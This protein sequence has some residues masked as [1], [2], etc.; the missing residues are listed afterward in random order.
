VDYVCDREGPDTIVALIEAMRAGAEPSKVPNLWYRA[1]DEVRFTH[2]GDLLDDLD[3]E[4]PGIAWDLLPMTRYR[5]HNWHAFPD[6]LARSPY[7]SIHTSLGCPYKC[8]FCCINAPFGKS[9]YR[10]WQPDSVA[11]EVETLV[12]KY[13]VRHIKFCDEMFVLNKEHV[14]GICDRFIER[15]FDVNIWA[16]A[17]VDTVRDE[18]LD[19]LKRAGFNW[20]CLGIESASQHVRDGAL[21]KYGSQDIT[22]TVR[23]IQ[24]AGINVIGNYIFGLRDDTIASMRETLDMAVELNC[25]F[26]NFYSAMAYPGSKLYEQAVAKF[27]ALPKQWHHYSQ[28]GYETL[29]LPTDRCSAADV[30]RF[31]D[32]AFT[33]Y[34]TNTSYLDMVKRKFGQPVVDHIHRMTAIG[35]KRK[36]LEAA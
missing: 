3:T 32:A 13:G 7:A 10:L 36:L 15:K 8:T 31:R 26:A 29:P 6:I 33:T 4:A 18:F 34:F 14:L 5:A 12:S 24:N 30:L 22:D 1:G 17:R 2:R 35:L 21:K 19:K 11:R 27:Y 28:H 9:S 20:L 16:Y 25:E 23:R